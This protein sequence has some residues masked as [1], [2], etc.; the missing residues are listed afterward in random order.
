M[1]KEFAVD[2]INSFRE[3]ALSLL[4]VMAG[5]IAQTLETIL[6]QLDEEIGHPGKGWESIGKR[7]RRLIT[8]FG[9]EIVIKRRG[10][11][12]KAGRRTEI[13][14]PLDQALGLKPEERYCPLVQQIAIELATKLS[15]REAAAILEN[16]FLVAVSHQEIHRWVTEAGGVRETEEQERAAALTKGEKQPKR[17]SEREIPAVVI[18][19]DGLYI[20]L[21]R[22][23]ER[24]TELKLGIVHEGWR[25]ETPRGER[26]ELIGKACWGGN[27]STEE[28][29]ERGLVRL[30]EK[31]DI[32]KIQR[33]I[34]SGDGDKWI[35][36]GEEYLGAEWYLDRYHLHRAIIEGLSHQPKR[37]AKIFEALA[38]GDLNRLE[39]HLKEAIETTKE[40]RQRQKAEKLWK[41]LKA[42]W[43]GLVDWRQRPG[44]QP[45]GAKGLGAMEGQVRHIAAA[46]MKRRGAS[47]SKKGANNMLQLRLLAKMN[48]LGAWLEKWQSSRWPEITEQAS[49]IA[50]REVIKRLKAVKS[51]EWLRSSLPLLR[52]KYRFSPLGRAL[53][54]LSC[55]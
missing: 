42:N 28:F 51:G 50:A 45:E 49:Q 33:I 35:R 5:I 44:P 43:E 9:L 53:Y 47:W 54:S 24:V 48:Q 41:Y 34:L 37:R 32:N 12:R 23:K 18:E 38:A 11:R 19:A 31:C 2:H 25:R 21:Q 13:I 36:E 15:F 17:Q 52:T 26:Y 27:L 16:T 20:R 7:E 55:N 39:E 4:K 40:P 6:N 22:E 14:F 8:L 3:F 30:S 10:Y 1:I 29:W 46:R